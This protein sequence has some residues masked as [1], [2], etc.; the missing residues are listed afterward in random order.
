MAKTKRPTFTDEE[1]HL[2]ARALHEAG[3]RNINPHGVH[4]YDFR[5]DEGV[6]HNM[7]ALLDRA[8]PDFAWS[9][10][11]ID[12]VKRAIDA[13]YLPPPGGITAQS[14]Q[15]FLSAH[16]AVKVSREDVPL[17]AIRKDRV[18]PVFTDPDLPF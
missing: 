2:I 16:D 13:G 9:A 7:W 1:M 6:G 15:E 12:D 14:I 10:Q 18:R 4:G 3:D 11:Q 8:F 5:A 17:P